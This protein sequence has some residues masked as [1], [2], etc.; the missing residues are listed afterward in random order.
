[1]GILDN[2]D[3]FMVE[4]MDVMEVMRQLNPKKKK[5][6]DDITKKK[7][8]NV[9]RPEMWEVAKLSDEEVDF[10]KNLQLLYSDVEEISWLNKIVDK[11][12][13]TRKREREMEPAF[14]REPALNPFESYKAYLESKEIPQNMVADY[15]KRAKA[16]R[17]AGGSVEIDE[18]L[19]TVA[20]TMSDGSEYFFQE[21]EASELL[22]QVPDNMSPEDFI[23]AYAQGW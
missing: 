5:M 23:L 3:R 15:E 6:L 4:D 13:H 12:K 9:H 21:T 17:D 19:P 20:V 16:E 22:D 7:I 8:A 18:R 1:M 14:A 10:L 2:L 11:I